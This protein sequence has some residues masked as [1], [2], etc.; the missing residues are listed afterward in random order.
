M[1]EV[2]DELSHEYNKTIREKQIMFFNIG[3]KINQLH[4]YYIVAI[5]VL[6]KLLK[7]S[8]ISIHLNNLIRFLPT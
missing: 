5:T 6:I 2:W 8:S 1:D 4:F 3:E 7:I